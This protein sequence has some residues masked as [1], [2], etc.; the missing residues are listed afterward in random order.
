[1]LEEACSKKGKFFSADLQPIL[2]SK[3]RFCW[4]Q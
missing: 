4:A 1:M 3:E 2:C